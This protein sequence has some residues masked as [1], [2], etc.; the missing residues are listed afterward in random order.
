MVQITRFVLL[1]LC[2]IFLQ[3]KS[4]E[5]RKKQQAGIGKEA[6]VQPNSVNPEAKRNDQ[7]S[8]GDVQLHGPKV[9]SEEE[10]IPLPIEET[11]N[12]GAVEN[13]DKVCFASYHSR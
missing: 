3:E 11:A 6:Q 12:T 7:G 2:R 8:N 1:P 5:N 10:M 9:C 13:E 4:A